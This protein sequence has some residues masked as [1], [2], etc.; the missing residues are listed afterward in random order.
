MQARAVEAYQKWVAAGLKLKAY[1]DLLGLAEGRTSGIKRQVQLGAEP[2]I[3]LTENDVNLVR[4][5][6][7]VIEARQDFQAAAVKLS[8]YY[9]NA[10]G[11]PIM[12][13]ESRLPSQAAALDGIRPQYAFEL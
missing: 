7:Y 12:V 5:Q 1:E 10:G 13:D 4:R 6:A 8:L 2:D 11:E 9:R 3:L